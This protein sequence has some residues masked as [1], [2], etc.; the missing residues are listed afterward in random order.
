VIQDRSTVTVE[1][2][3]ILACD[4]SNA[5]ISSDL[6]QHLTCMSES[7]YYWY[8]ISGKLYKLLLYLQWKT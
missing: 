6:M 8:L 7:Q 1:H 2:Q 5:A 3:Y 4:L